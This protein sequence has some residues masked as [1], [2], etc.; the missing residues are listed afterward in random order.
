MARTRLI[1]EVALKLS[2]VLLI[3][4]NTLARAEGLTNAE[5]LATINQALNDARKLAESIEEAA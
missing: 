5:I 3:E 1:S 4:L 2:H